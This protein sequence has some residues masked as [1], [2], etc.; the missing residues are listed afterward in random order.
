M[1]AEEFSVRDFPLQEQLHSDFYVTPSWRDAIKMHVTSKAFKM[2][3]KW[4]LST[5][6]YWVI[7]QRRFGNSLP[8]FWYDL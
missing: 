1:L 8:T 4:E 2:R 3:E 5:V 6:L 7:T